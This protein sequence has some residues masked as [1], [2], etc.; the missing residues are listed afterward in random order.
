MNDFFPKLVRREAYQGA[1][2]KSGYGR[3]RQEIAEDC[4]RRCV[5]CDCPEEDIGGEPMMEL[6]HFRPE[7]YF[8][9]LRDD[10]TNLVYA[11]RS[12]NG[13]KRHDWPAGSGEITHVDGEGYLDPFVEQRTM[14]LRVLRSGFI[15]P[16]NPPG[17]Y[18]VFKLGLNRP[19]LRSLRKRRIL[20]N[21]LRPRVQAAIDALHD[22][23][24][25]S[26]P[27]V[28]DVLDEAIRVLRAHSV[29]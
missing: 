26:T 9:G 28:R 15:E 2:G 14:Y 7:A 12:C 19:L 25:K 13:K 20:R 22:L 16:L 11:C 18:L 8:E 10:P 23:S 29:L 27:E 21:S 24:G 6:D 17:A 5:Y 3:F 1:H 4:L